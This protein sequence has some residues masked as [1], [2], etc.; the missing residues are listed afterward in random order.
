[1]NLRIYFTA[2]TI[3]MMVWPKSGMAQSSDKTMDALEINHTHSLHQVNR[4]WTDQNS[5]QLKLSDFECHPV[6]VVMFYGQCTGTCPVLIQRTWKL[7]T[8]I[9]EKSWEKVKVLA[10][11][12]DYENDTPEALKA[13]AEY[14]QLDL[15]NWHFVTAPHRTIREMAMLLGVQY[16]QRSDGHYEHTN[17]ITILDGEGR[18]V[19]RIEGLT[20]DLSE[21]AAKLMG[22]VKR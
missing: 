22:M 21:P 9:D 8:E 2:I 12:F 11:S 15:P 18:V 13:Y 20:G 1:M 6:I 17:L 7:Y 4:N 19:E 10:I 5:N 3:L 16:R 14:E